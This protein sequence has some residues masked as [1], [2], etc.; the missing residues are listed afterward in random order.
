MVMAF[1]VTIQEKENRCT[2]L[3]ILHLNETSFLHPKSSNDA[4]TSYGH[5]F[6][7]QKVPIEDD[8][9]DNEPDNIGNKIFNN[10]QC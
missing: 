4:S 2:V 10:N 8:A 9:Y 5:N 3:S 7:F 6:L 1:I